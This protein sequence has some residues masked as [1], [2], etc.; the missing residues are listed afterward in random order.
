MDLDV[1]SADDEIVQVSSHPDAAVLPRRKK[2]QSY[3]NM[4]K[5]TMF[6]LLYILQS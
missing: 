4:S 2:K 6:G 3:K 5:K 1:D